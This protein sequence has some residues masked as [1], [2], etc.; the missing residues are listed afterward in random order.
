MMPPND[1]A[2]INSFE[3]ET[4]KSKRPLFF[5]SVTGKPNELL[6]FVLVRVDVILP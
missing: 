1:W 5:L 4:R 2:Y 6:R 3:L